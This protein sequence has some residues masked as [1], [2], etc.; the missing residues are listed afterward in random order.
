MASC[1]NMTLPESRVGTA[2]AASEESGSREASRPPRLETLM[3][4]RVAA[5]RSRLKSAPAKRWVAGVSQGIAE[6]SVAH[7]VFVGRVT[8][9][10]SHIPG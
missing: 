6:E 3:S 10:T 8:D 1:V 7:R 5:A 9:G 2:S 4:S